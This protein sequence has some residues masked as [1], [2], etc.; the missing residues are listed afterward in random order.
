MLSV[1][2]L[3]TVWYIRKCDIAVQLPGTQ[4]VALVDDLVNLLSCHWLDGH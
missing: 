1:F 4:P 2:F 3:S